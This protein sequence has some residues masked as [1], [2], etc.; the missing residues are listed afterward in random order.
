MAEFV[1]ALNAALYGALTG[2]APLTALLAGTA[3]VYFAQAPDE[4]TLPYVVFSYAGGPGHE[5]QS[6]HQTV[7]ELVFVRGYA[8]APALAGSI[9]AQIDAA[10]HGVTLGVSGWANF[11]TARGQ[12]VS[13]VEIDSAQQKTWARGA[14]YRVRLEAT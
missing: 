1:N 5:N 3:A 9:A 14:M 4:A 11:W 7:D 8:A 13:Q 6:P 12:S 10:L 2:R